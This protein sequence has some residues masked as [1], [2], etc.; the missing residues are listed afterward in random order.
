MG[1]VGGGRGVPQTPWRGRREEGQHRRP[2]SDFL[3]WESPLQGADVSSQLLF[4]QLEGLHRPLHPDDGLHVVLK[5]VPLH[6]GISTLDLVKYPEESP[7]DMG[8][9]QGGRDHGGL[10]LGALGA[11]PGESWVPFTLSAWKNALALHTSRR[12]GGPLGACI[13]AGAEDGLPP[14]T[15]G[16]YL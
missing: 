1:R 6:V 11:S 10:R 2:H 16:F 12:L 14:I 5:A 4:L 8:S 15:L 9:E 13:W 3:P 7:E